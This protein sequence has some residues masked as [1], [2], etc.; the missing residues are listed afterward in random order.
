[1]EN[2]ACLLADLQNASADP[3]LKRIQVPFDSSP[4]V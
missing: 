4:T 2:S 3:F 1:M